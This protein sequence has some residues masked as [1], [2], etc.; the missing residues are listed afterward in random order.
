MNYEEKK[1]IALYIREAIDLELK[2]IID[3]SHNIM[4]SRIITFFSTIGSYKSYA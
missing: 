2:V 1:C 4:S 3:K